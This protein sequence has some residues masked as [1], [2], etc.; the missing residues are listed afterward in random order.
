MHSRRNPRIVNCYCCCFKSLNRIHNSLFFRINVDVTKM[1][2]MFSEHT[3]CEDFHCAL[4]CVYS[5]INFTI[6]MLWMRSIQNFL[7]Q[8]HSGTHISKRLTWLEM[9]CI[10]FG[11]EL[12][13]C[14]C[15]RNLSFLFWMTFCQVAS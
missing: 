4:L 12:C 1:C 3:K 14:V 10:T 11:N 7:L 9:R 13:L 15:V 8:F 2:I 5:S 6:L